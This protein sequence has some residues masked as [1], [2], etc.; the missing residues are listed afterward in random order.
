MTENSYSVF[1]AMVDIVAS[2]RTALGEIK[3]HSGWMWWPLLINLLLSAG[4]FVYYYNWV[5][6]PWLVEEAIRNLPVESRAENAAGV[7]QFMQRESMLWTSVIAVVVM[8]FVIYFLQATWFHLANKLT[9]GA[10]ISYGQWFSF[11]VWTGFVGVF[12]SLAAFAMMFLSDS[13]QI[14]VESL[15]VLSFNSLLV[16]ANPGEPWFT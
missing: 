16:H 14:A 6:F 9:T 4:M 15:A 13:N 5:D 8:T 10:E 1:N 11:S 7:Q 3:T 2:P 12:G